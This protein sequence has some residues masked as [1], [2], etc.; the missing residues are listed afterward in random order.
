[1]ANRTYKQIEED[2]KKVKQ[3]AE[4]ATTIKEVEDLTGLSKS[5]I[6]TTLSKHPI[7]AKRL[8]DKIKSNNQTKKEQEK[9]AS[10]MEQKKEQVQQRNDNKENA[11]SGFVI[12]ASLTGTVNFIETMQKMFLSEQKIILTDITMYELSKLQ[13]C[14]GI[15]GTDARYILNNAIEYPENFELVPIEEIYDIPDDNIIEFCKN[16]NVI[17]LTAD[18]EM[19]LK[20]RMYHIE[21]RYHKKLREDFIQTLLVAHKIENNLVITGF[22]RKDISICV[23]SNGIQYSKG[24]YFLNIGDDVFVSK[25][26]KDYIT[27]A[28]YQIISLKETNNCDLLYSRRIYDYDNVDLDKK[29]YTSFVKDFVHMIRNFA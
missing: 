29:E 23:Y 6:T 12:D 5:Q 10:S 15:H 22:Q 27:F 26:R 16:K 18:K 20:A 7:A 14:K 2:Y 3:A 28:H 25:K 24:K 17:L 1:M 19:L 9:L 8:R 11:I 4:T 13:K 21:V